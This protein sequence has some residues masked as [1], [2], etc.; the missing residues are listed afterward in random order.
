MSDFAP[1]D[2]PQHCRMARTRAR[3]NARAFAGA[4]IARCAGLTALILSA[5]RT[6]GV[7]GRKLNMSNAEIVRRA[8]QARRLTTFVAFN[9]SARITWIRQTEGGKSSKIS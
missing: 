1:V 4:V 6:S 8:P 9:M 3:I 7:L 5:P 2:I